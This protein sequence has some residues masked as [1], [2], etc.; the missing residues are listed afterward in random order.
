MKKTTSRLKLKNQYCNVGAW[1]RI[2]DKRDSMP[3]YESVKWLTVRQEIIYVKDTGFKKSSHERYPSSVMKYNNL[4]GRCIHCFGGM[5]FHG[6]DNFFANFYIPGS[7]WFLKHRLEIA[8]FLQL[9]NFIVLCLFALSP[10][11]CIYCLTIVVIDIVQFRRV[12]W[13]A[14]NICRWISTQIWAPTPFKDH[15]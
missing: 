2:W 10:I 12:L 7:Y 6:V 8:N 11:H 3:L 1:C 14:I 15:V 9:A 13:C 5:K 4:P